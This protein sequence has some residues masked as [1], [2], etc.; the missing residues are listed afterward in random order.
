MKKKILAGY[1][2]ALQEMDFKNRGMREVKEEETIK[3]GG[4]AYY[5]PKGTFVVDCEPALLGRWLYLQ[6]LINNEYKNN[7]GLLKDLQ[8]VMNEYEEEQKKESQAAA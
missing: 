7:K 5:L 3:H 1:K 6:D 4:K 8:V 2:R